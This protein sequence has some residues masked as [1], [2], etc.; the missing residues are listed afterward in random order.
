MVELELWNVIVGS[1]VW[2]MNHAGS[3]TDYFSCYAVDT[4]SILR[5]EVVGGE[6]EFSSKVVPGGDDIQRHEVQK[7]VDMCLKS[8]M[9]YMV[10]VNSPIVQ[11]DSFGYLRRFREICEKGRAKNIF[12][13]IDGMARGNLIK[14]RKAGLDG[15][16]W[17]KKLNACARSVMFGI[18]W[19]LNGEAK[20]VPVQGAT[21]TQVF[22]LLEE[23]AHA[24]EKSRLP[25]TPPNVEEYR[26]FLF[27][28]RTA[29]LNGK[30]R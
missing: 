26:D 4:K 13:S 17:Q 28:V 29:S 9:N 18:T 23:L 8:N 25:E 10:A 16:E 20:F 27:E 24:K 2:G 15:L 12:G 19:L 5:G 30:I 1:H 7:W 14:Y 22:D 11:S 3:D 6:A 21:E